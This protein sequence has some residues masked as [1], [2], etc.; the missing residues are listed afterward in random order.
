MITRHAIGA[1][2]VDVYPDTR[3]VRDLHDHVVVQGHC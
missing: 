1:F 3:L 2:S